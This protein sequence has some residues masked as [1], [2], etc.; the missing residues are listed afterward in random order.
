MVDLLTKSPLVA[1]RSEGKL[2]LVDL[3]GSECAKKGGLIYSEDIGRSGGGVRRHGERSMELG[4]LV[5]YHDTLEYWCLMVYLMVYWD[6]VLVGYHCIISGISGIM[7]YLM[8][9]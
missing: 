3:A 9:C 6:I 7:V 4:T 1:L 8:R 5:R 2:H